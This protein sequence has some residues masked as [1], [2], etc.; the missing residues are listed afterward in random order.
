MDSAR[1]E[2]EAADW[3]ARRD[4]GHW[5]DAQGRAFEEWQEQSTAHR[6]A[7]LRIKAS[8][9]QADRLQALGAGV[10]RGQIPA[11]GTWRLSPFLEQGKRSTTAALTVDECDDEVEDAAVSAAARTSRFSKWRAW[12]AALVVGV[13]IAGGGY[14]T[15]Y[16]PDSYR[17][18]IGVTK[19]V[20]LADGS[21][22]MLNTN[23]AIHVELSAAQRRIDLDRGEAFF[24]VAK[25]P[26]RPFV[27]NAA[28]KRIVAVGTKF[29]VFREPLDT[30]VVVIEGQVNVEEVQNGGQAGPATP[31]SAGSI[32]QA[33]SAGVLIRRSTV[34]EAERYTSWRSGYISLRDTELA[35]A[36][37]EFNRYNS[38]QL[39]IADPSIAQMRI[40]GNLRA[41]NVEAFVRVL[42]EGFSVRADDQ[43]NRILLTGKSGH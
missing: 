40:G 33:G 29:S 4:S 17:S 16:D 3:L 32:A 1:I 18:A 28:G 34:A 37:A 12:A 2:R 8:W 6:I 39:V 20:R 42:E 21:T 38:K 36:V 14:L 15:S 11:P 26:G 27:V 23:T 10:P 19:V 9:Q 13:G 25:E 24:D 31:V 35:E 5:D 22:V 7:V 30:R 41:T 43:G